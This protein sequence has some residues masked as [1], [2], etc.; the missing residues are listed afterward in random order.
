MLEWILPLVCVSQTDQLAVLRYEPGSKTKAAFLE[1]R[2]GLPNLGSVKGTDLKLFAVGG[3]Q[4]IRF[5]FGADVDGDELDEVA[6]LSEWTSND[7]GYR[8]SVHSQPEKLFDDINVPERKSKKGEIGSRSKFGPIVAA[9]AANLDGVGADEIALVRKVSTGAQRLE[10]YSLPNTQ[11]AMGPVLAS[12]TELSNA[13][14]DE[15]LDLTGIDIDMDNHDELAL[16]CRAASGQV[17][18]DV[19]RSPTQPGDS[20]PQLLASARDVLKLGAVVGIDSLDADGDGRDELLIERAVVA[21][22]TRLEAYQRPSS[23]SDVLM[24]IPDQAPILLQNDSKLP[25]FAAFSLR[26]PSMKLSAG[27]ELPPEVLFENTFT[28]FFEHDIPG[29]YLGTTHVAMTPIPNAVGT[30]DTLSKT[31]VISLPNGATVS[32][33][34]DTASDSLTSNGVPIVMHDPKLPSS[35]LNLQFGSGKASVSDS[36]LSIQAIYSG[37]ITG[38][39]NPTSIVTNGKLLI[40][41]TK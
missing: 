40:L 17:R 41:M 36:V 38:G 33:K 25:L 26:G 13:S 37:Q 34:F 15:I 23:L 24:P 39:F 10:I 5:A 30:F 3:K 18:V 1:L 8:L 21:G 22:Y 29:G 20:F 19:L 7:A 4:P 31:V 16:L 11:G 2:T 32:A 6:I 9:D 12:F 27:G 14:T 28:C 35:M